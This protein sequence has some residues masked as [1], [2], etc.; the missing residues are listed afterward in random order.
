MDTLLV[1]ER[2][3]LI[4]QS[5]WNYLQATVVLI[6]APAALS[7]KPLVLWS[8]G[9][10]SPISGEIVGI[11]VVAGT[12]SV[13]VRS[14]KEYQFL[15]K[16]IGVSV[17]WGAIHRSKELLITRSFGL[18]CEF[19]LH[20]TEGKEFY[21][22]SLSAESNSIDVMKMQKCK[23]NEIIPNLYIPSWKI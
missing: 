19:L 20:L 17:G 12:F 8:V 3:T 21:C 7:I 4:Y 15:E 14:F 22:E 2:I 9:T 23:R 11:W 13:S 5:Q 6:P 1:Q 16:R 10:I 18:F